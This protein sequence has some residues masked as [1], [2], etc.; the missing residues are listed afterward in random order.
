VVVRR[1]A[2]PLRFARLSP[3]PFTER[4]VSKFSLPVVGWREKADGMATTD[5]SEV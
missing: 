4:L 5:E 3:A 2:Q 1:G